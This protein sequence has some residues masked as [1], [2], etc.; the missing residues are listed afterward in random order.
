M[1]SVNTTFKQMETNQFYNTRSFNTHQLKRQNFKTG[2][3]GS[4][5]ILSKCLSNWNLLQNALKTNFLKN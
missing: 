4:F 5:S 2:K 3:Y 1:K